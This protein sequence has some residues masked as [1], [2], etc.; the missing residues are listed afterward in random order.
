MYCIHCHITMAKSDVG[1]FSDFSIL[2]KKI[3]GLTSDD[4]MLLL[5]VG[6]SWT[7]TLN[8]QRS[9]QD[10]GMMSLCVKCWNRFIFS[11][12]KSCLLPFIFFKKEY[13]TYGGT[14]YKYRRDIVANFEWKT[15]CGVSFHQIL[16][17][18]GCN[19]STWSFITLWILSW[20]VL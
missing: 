15:L 2:A 7:W 8:K 13:P 20:E 3:L 6:S 12:L 14:S 16:W 4:L 9:N 17:A 5:Q 18:Q 10:G 1:I 11:E 19:F